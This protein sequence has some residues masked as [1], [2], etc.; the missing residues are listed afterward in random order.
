MKEQKINFLSDHRAADSINWVLQ[1]L[2]DSPKQWEWLHSMHTEIPDADWARV[3]KDVVKAGNQSVWVVVQPELATASS[4][5]RKAA[6][7]ASAAV[8]ALLAYREADEMLK[9][10]RFVPNTPASELMLV[11]CMVDANT[12]MRPYSED[13]YKASMARNVG[14]VD[15]RDDELKRLQAELAEVK[16]DR[17]MLKSLLK[18]RQSQTDTATQMQT[19]LSICSLLAENYELQREHKNLQER[20]SQAE[21]FLAKAKSDADFIVPQSGNV[22]RLKGRIV[23]LQEACKHKDKALNTAKE[24]RLQLVSTIQRLEKALSKRKSDSEVV[25][26]YRQILQLYM[27]QLDKLLAV[28]VQL[29]AKIAQLKAEKAP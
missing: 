5:N 11:A 27:K 21:K 18:D 1:S 9:T 7:R 17:D 12:D 22:K 4:G 23:E 10:G 14:K 13:L 19:T 24:A 6:Y 26:N 29:R 8:L 15:A 20:Y 25:D 3:S 2:L 28:I 16:A